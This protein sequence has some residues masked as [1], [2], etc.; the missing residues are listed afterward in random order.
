M[1]LR[2]LRVAYR[3]L[4]AVVPTFAGR[5]ATDAFG[6]TRSLTR[7]PEDRTPLGAQRFPLASHA[8]IREGYL[9]T[10]RG[11]TALLVHGWASDSSSM[12]G[13]VRPLR[14]LGFQVATFDAPAHGISRGKTTT[15]TRFTR[16]VKDVLDTLGDVEVIVAHSLGSIA[17]VAA[18]M[19]RGLAR[20]PRCIVLLSPTCTLTEVLERWSAGHFKLPRR[21]VEGIFKELHRRNGVPVSHWNIVT[22]GKGLDV[23][24][25]VIHDPGDPVV[26]FREAERV[27]ASLPRV[28]LEKAPRLGHV[29][30]LSALDVNQR[31]MAF[32][33]SRAFSPRLKELA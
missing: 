10:G 16:A 33:S 1:K 3:A 23:P 24:V 18:V 20:A 2:A 26:P 30:I 5:L 19:E 4:N 27:A 15:M 9:W 6:Y 29:R 28:T 7:A 17:T 13:F 14:S 12:Y 8:E 21:V 11:A 25:L 22:L 32:I 31:V